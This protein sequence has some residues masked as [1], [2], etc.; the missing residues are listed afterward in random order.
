MSLTGIFFIFR[1]SALYL[2]TP[3]SKRNLPTDIE[4]ERSRVKI[5]I[6]NQ[7][8]GV[9]NYSNWECSKPYERH[10]TSNKYFNS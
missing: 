7:S 10:K 6:L 2:R 1:L 8:N 3:Y 9:F 5:H 4:T